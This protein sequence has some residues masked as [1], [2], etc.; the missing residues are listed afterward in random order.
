MTKL[1]VEVHKKGRRKLGAFY[2]WP[3]GRRVYLAWL[4]LN[5]M[6]TRGEKSLSAALLSGKACWGLSRDDVT[7]A[8][9]KR[10]VAM[11]VRVKDNGDIFLASMKVVIDPKSA[12]LIEGFPNRKH[13]PVKL[14]HKKA[15]RVRL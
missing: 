9:L 8:R 11:G 5:S 3:D 6:F 7:L 12:V 10:C 13:I 4:T 2:I 15:G 1:T 14:F